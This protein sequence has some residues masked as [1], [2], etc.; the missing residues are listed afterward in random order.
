MEIPLTEGPFL[1]ETLNIPHTYCWS[2]ALAP[3]PRDWAEHIDV[4]GFIFRQPPQ[5][6]PTPELDAFLK[7]GDVP[8]Y[9]GFGSIVVDD[10]DQLL[11]TVLQAMKALGRRAIIS[12]GWS[13]LDTRLAPQ[14]VL[15]IDDCP[16]EWLFQH[17]RAVVHHGGAGTTAAGLAAGKPTVIVP[18]FG[19]QP[20]WGDRVAEIGAGPPPIPHR[21][22]T[23]ENL[24]QAIHFCFDPE[25]IAAAKHV[26]EQ[27]KAEDGAKAA[28][29]SF[30]RQLD[31]K[32]LRCDLI[33]TLPA[34][35]EYT[36]RTS[37]L[38]GKVIKISGLAA[39][40]LSESGRI[41]LEDLISYRPRPIVIENRRWDPFTSAASA[42]VGIAFDLISTTNDIWYAPYKL[43]T[44]QTS[45]T[46]R[47]SS[48]GT[49]DAEEESS[50]LASKNLQVREKAKYVSSSAIN[51]P[52][53]LGV[54][55]KGLA[56][57]APFAI[58]EG[59]RAAP[60]LLGEEVKD[61]K[62]ITDWKSGLEVGCTEF[63]RGVGTGVV[64]I[65]VQ[66]YKG[67]K[68]H[69]AL[70]FA[71]GIGRGAIGTLT[72]A[73]SGMFGLVGYPAQG[74]YRT[75]YAV[76][77]GSAKKQ[78]AKARRIHEVYFAGTKAGK[79]DEESVLRQ[80]DTL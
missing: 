9:I 61:H 58:A 48:M 20:F 60:R 54:F 33:P 78:V 70:G 57:D 31:A 42:T 72:K 80:Y 53:L 40:I 44:R 2:S 3:R 30:H 68:D 52:K 13:Q 75:A 35:F 56:I 51:V 23:P 1:A 7:A 11:E 79:Y 10:P 5:Y 41:K 29:D 64:D 74:F 37:V 63:V 65:L 19:D 73:G 22:L 27:I 76:S 16:H 12:K 18:F 28:V 71:A 49:A 36:K 47:T 15:F 69:G 55:A 46:S 77:H 14:D 67:A 32:V 26:S 39:D 66:P 34:V 38:K 17:V 43:H 24:A 6:T 8:I 4:T 21:K 50:S 45:S 25:V 59:F 62:P